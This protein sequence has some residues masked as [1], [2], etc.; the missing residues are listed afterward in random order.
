MSAII[1]KA[2]NK[3][4]KILKEFA[5]KLGA[6]VLNINEELFEDLALGLLMD[7]SKTGKV[8]GRDTIFKQLDK[9]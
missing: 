4:T 9:K 7:K 6:D 8:V 2:D 5:K 1:I 3:N